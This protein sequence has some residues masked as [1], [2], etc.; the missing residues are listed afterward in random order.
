M[1]SFTIF[2]IVLLVCTMGV[3][4]CKKKPAGPEAPT[5]LTAPETYDLGNVKCPVT[6]KAV[7]KKAFCAYNKD[8]KD[9]TVYFATADAKKAFEAAAKDEKK[10][11]DFEGY[12]KKLD[13]TKAKKNEVKVEV[14]KVKKAVKK[15]TVKKPVVKTPAKPKTK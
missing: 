2:M 11:A 6:D 9:Y 8:K 12:V 14:K 3:V 10:K 13:F 5:D 4:G 1:K 7:D 15:T